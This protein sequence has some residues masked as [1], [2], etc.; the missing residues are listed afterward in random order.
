MTTLTPPIDAQETIK[1]L[2]PEASEMKPYEIHNRVLRLPHEIY[3]TQ[4][5]WFDGQQKLDGMETKERA[6][7]RA[8]LAVSGT[9]ETLQSLEDQVSQSRDIQDERQ[10]VHAMKMTIELKQNLFDAYK[11]LANYETAKLSAGITD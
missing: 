8:I 4:L 11:K 5:I 1:A 7:A 2:E 6:A 9:K 10:K 3:Q